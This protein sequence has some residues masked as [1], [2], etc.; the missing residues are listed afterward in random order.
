MKRIEVVA[1]KIQET[2]LKAMEDLKQDLK[3]DL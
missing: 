2:H 1:E 3:E